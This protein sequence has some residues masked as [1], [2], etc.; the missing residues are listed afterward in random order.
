M[1]ESNEALAALAREVP[2][3]IPPASVNERLMSRIA[4]T[5]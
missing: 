1:R 2:P 3:A 5:A 4:D